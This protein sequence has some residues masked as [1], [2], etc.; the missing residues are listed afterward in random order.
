MQCFAH[1]K[2]C[3]STV[4][5]AAITVAF[6]GCDAEPARVQGRR[7]PADNSQNYCMMPRTAATPE[8]VHPDP[9]CA[10]NAI[11]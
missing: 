2:H 1:A 7:V 11:S 8:V 5:L 4:T 3:G 6:T 10:E 9:A